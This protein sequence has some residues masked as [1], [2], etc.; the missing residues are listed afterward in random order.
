MRF[1]FDYR[2]SDQSLYDYSGDYFGTPQAAIEFAGAIAE[3]LKHSLTEDWMGWAIEVR[4]AEGMK[5]SSIPVKTA[6]L[7][8]A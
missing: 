4:N 6:G 1:F 2:T 5:F 3:N 8:A 7:A